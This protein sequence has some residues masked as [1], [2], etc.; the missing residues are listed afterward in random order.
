M[1][2][3]VFC[4]APCKPRY[5]RLVDAIYP[6]NDNPRSLT[7]GLIHG[8]MQKLTFYAISQPEKLVRI[9]EY[10]VWRMSRDLYRQRYN[11][12]KIS[13]EAMDQLLQS[14]HDLSSLNQFI[15]SF[16]KMLQKL[17]ETNNFEMEELA[18]DSFVNFAH[19]EEN[20]P[21]Y[22]R[23]Y[24]FFISKFAAM[25]HSNQG[26]NAKAIRYAGLRGLRGVLWKSA[27]DPLQ[28]SIWEKQHMDKIVP[29]ILFNLQDDESQQNTEAVANA[30]FLDQPYAVDDVADSPKALSDQ[31]LRELMAKAPF[32][33][34]SVLEPVLK[35]CDLHKKWEPPATF[36]V[37]TFRAIMYS[38]KDPCFVIQALINH[39]E[40]MSNSNASIR[41]GIATVLSSIVS[42]A[43]TSIFNSLLKHLRQSVEFQ[44]SKECPSAEEEK[45]YQ[46]T[47]INAMGDYANALPDYQKVEIMMFTVGNIPKL[48]EDGRA[49]KPGDA[50]LQNVLVKTLLK[51]A[52]KYKTA[53]LATIFADSFLGTLLQ[54]ALVADPLVRLDTQQIFHTLLDRHDNVS[55]LEH[56]PYLPDVADLQ[57][58]VE[59][60]SRADQMFMQKHVLAFTNMLYKSV[61]LIPETNEVEMMKHIDA[62][63][64]TMA[65]LCVE[66]GIDEVIVELFRLSFALQ[67]IAVDS[68]C[69][70]AG[71]KRIAIHS[72]VARYLNLSSQLMAIP[73]LCQHV[74]QVVN[75]RAIR[76]PIPLNHLAEGISNDSSLSNAF[77]SSNE[78]RYAAVPIQEDASSLL[79]DKNDV[80]E[81]LKASG[82]DVQRFAIPFVT[83]ANFTTNDNDA[84]SRAIMIDRTDNFSGMGMLN[85]FANGNAAQ[86]IVDDSTISIDMSIDWTPPDSRHASRRNTLFANPR[87][88]DIFG[89]P[90]S[91]ADLRKTLNNRLDGMEEERREQERSCTEMTKAIDVE[92]EMLPT[93]PYIDFECRAEA[94]HQCSSGLLSVFWTLITISVLLALLPRETLTE[95]S[96]DSGIVGNVIM[97]C[98]F[99]VNA[100]FGPYSLFFQER[101][102][103]IL[104]RF[105]EQPF[106]KL[107]EC[108]QKDKNETDLS[109]TL[110]RL[111]QRSNDANR[112]NEFALSEKPKNIFELKMPESFVY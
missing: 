39:L 1:D 42:I 13:V 32:G 64:C 102:R 103:E 109:H 81:M 15:E 70:F 96:D 4:C 84:S 82:K 22:H 88:G 51:V 79:F 97:T 47:L 17:L 9:G 48:G 10:I 71:A 36:A 86:S 21:A 68:S 100:S 76:G 7:E 75:E 108:I 55:L 35:H 87:G 57:L 6:S 40:N 62:V 89:L 66:V 43:G 91:V 37:M 14:C 110:N 111:L 105:R 56:L 101:T 94:S 31:F 67:A 93:A 45:I 41:I 73:S 74:Q 16:L 33:L 104:E 24:D 95:V 85:G 29:S 38:I 99:E 50:F 49:S 27:A 80:A 46:V 98:N 23:Q 26:E 59:K 34:I 106:D 5:R 28:A 112:I 19:I 18:T 30:P 2:G 53:Y 58:T 77:A 44:L 83:K 25:C 60:C 52:T 65:L 72:L 11:Q 90:L 20:T 92:P 54:L 69:G 63:L 8:N 3:F 12:V 78:Q 61:Y 107:V